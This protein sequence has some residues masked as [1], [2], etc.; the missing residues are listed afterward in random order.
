MSLLSP[1]ILPLSLACPPGGCTLEPVPAAAAAAYP[2]PL[3]APHA[4]VEEERK[5]DDLRC[6]ALPPAASRKKPTLSNISSC[7]C[8][9]VLAEIRA[10]CRAEQPLGD[11]H[12]ER[13]TCPLYDGACAEV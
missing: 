8:N 2:E 13:F 6:A 3:T 9:R 1:T 7:E 5:K 11:L 12:L 10:Y 4:C